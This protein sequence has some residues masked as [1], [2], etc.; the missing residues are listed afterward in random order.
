MGCDYYE[1]LQYYFSYIRTVLIRRIREHQKN[2]A[3]ADS[4]D[5]SDGEGNTTTV[6]K[7]G[8]MKKTG[9]KNEVVITR[10]LGYTHQE[11]FDRRQQK[12]ERNKLTTSEV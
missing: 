6:I 2:M 8:G 11:D 9:E 7:I 4:G 12:E 1:W 3:D 10:E 5:E